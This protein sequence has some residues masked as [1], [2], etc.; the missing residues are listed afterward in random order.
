MKTISTI[1]GRII[2]LEKK[3]PSFF[4]VLIFLFFLLFTLIVYHNSLKNSF[5]FDDAWQIT[6]NPWITKPS[7]IPNIFS[8][9]VWGFM[10]DEDKNDYYRPLMHVFFLVEYSLFGVSR[11]GFH[12][13]SIVL[14][15]AVA[16]T[17][18]LT[19]Y[20]LFRKKRIQLVGRKNFETFSFLTPF[21]AALLFVVHPI[22]SE[23]VYW[24][25]TAPELLYSLF[26]LLAFFFHIRDNRFSS[27][28]LSLFFF[29]LS[30]LS[31]ET[32]ISYLVFIFLLDIIFAPSQSKEAFFERLFLWMKRNW[33]F[34]FVGSMYLCVRFFVVSVHDDEAMIR[35]IILFFDFFINGP[36]LAVHYLGILI[37]PAT[38]SFFY[39]IDNPWNIW[40]PGIVYGVTLSIIMIGGNPW[41]RIKKE[42]LFFGLLLFFV[43]LLP[44]LN[45]S[46]LGIYSL[47]DRYVYLSSAGFFLFF[48]SILLMPFSWE[49]AVIRKKRV[50]Y[51]AGVA[52]FLVF[53]VYGILSMK[54]S[55]MWT[56]TVSLFSDSYEKFPQSGAADMLARE[57]LR[58]G[59]I[60]DFARIAPNA[61]LIDSPEESIFS[62]KSMRSKGYP[63]RLLGRAYL[64]N[65]EP[66]KSLSVFHFLFEVAPPEGKQ[67]AAAYRDMGLAYFLNGDSVLFEYYLEKS[68]TEN[69]LNFVTYRNLGQ[70]RCFQGKRDDSDKLFER[71]VQLGDIPNRV[72][73]VR[74]NC[75]GQYSFSETLKKADLFYD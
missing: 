44:V 26:F 31:K 7:N 22:N 67:R 71:A 68:L 24:I 17:F 42:T 34:L 55:S 2:F 61:Y 64:M 43:P 35:L 36:A 39:S 45:Y 25:S 29:T 18:F 47:S 52:F 12:F 59:R 57:F 56:D 4:V 8:S 30:L 53:C 14:H 48:S 49:R 62:E 21:L 3:H 6:N 60:D 72:K 38:Q 15:S 20:F 19:T 16:T 51:S 10:L 65:G 9:N 41:M 13:V 40:I 63:I 74:N 23:V 66:N 27:M 5:V 37:F 33:M 69:P 75:G 54:R 28:V 46:L 1:F 32:A 58:L 70:V 11:K 73:F 50:V